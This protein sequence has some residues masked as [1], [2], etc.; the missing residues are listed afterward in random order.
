M[1]LNSWGPI[2]LKID[3]LAENRSHAF[4]SRRATAA[5]MGRAGAGDRLGGDGLRGVRHSGGVD[6]RTRSGCHRAASGVG[7]AAR[8]PCHPRVTTPIW[9]DA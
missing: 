7:N 5:R 1:L 6:K 9:P 8:L 3:S 4:G 2:L